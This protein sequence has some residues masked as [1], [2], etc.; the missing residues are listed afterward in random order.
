MRLCIL[1]LTSLGLMT[2]CATTTLIQQPAAQPIH[3]SLPPLPYAYKALE[4]VIDAETMTIHH[5]KHHQT[6]VDNLNKALASSPE[7]DKPLEE[8][9]KHASTLPAA[10]RNNGGG[11]FNHSFFWKSSSWARKSIIFPAILRTTL[12]FERYY[13]RLP[14]ERKAEA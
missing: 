10:I 6:Y 13:H 9:F 11:H 7:S 4:P 1:A 8:L 3:Y 5:D 14:I 2:G 12:I